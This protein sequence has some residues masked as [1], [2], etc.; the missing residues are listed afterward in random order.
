MNADGK[1]VRWTVLMRNRTDRALFQARAGGGILHEVAFLGSEYRA[2]KNLKGADAL[3]LP[4]DFGFVRD[5]QLAALITKLSDPQFKIWSPHPLPVAG[6][7]FSLFAESGTEKYAIGVD[8]ALRPQRIKITTATGVGSGL[9]IYGD[10]YKKEKV[11]YPKTL[12]IKSEG[13]QQGIDVRFDTVELSPNL[14][15][16]DYKLKGKPLMRLDD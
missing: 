9:I 11:S 4:T 1:S 5:Y 10:Y 14:N 3:E 15:D 12:Q 13:R 8:S 7:E 2:S 6:E 16:L